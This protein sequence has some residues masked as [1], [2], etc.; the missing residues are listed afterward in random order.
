MDFFR[1]IN[2]F[3]MCV[4]LLIGIVSLVSVFLGETHQ[5]YI[6]L[7]CSVAYFIMYYEEYGKNRN[8]RGS[9]DTR[10]E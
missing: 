9:N 5:W 6:V 10:R 8:K 3:L 2:I 1:I 4:L 7:F